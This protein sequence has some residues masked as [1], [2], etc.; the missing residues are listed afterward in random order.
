MREKLSEIAKKGDVEAFKNA[1][2]QIENIR[3]T[4]KNDKWN[5]LLFTSDYTK[6]D[7]NK[8]EHTKKIEMLKLLLEKGIELNMS[9][10]WGRPINHVVF[11]IR[12][13]GEWA[14]YDTQ[15]R[16][17]FIYELLIRSEFTLPLPDEYFRI[18][19]SELKKDEF[20]QYVGNRKITDPM[21]FK[22]LQSDIK[23]AVEAGFFTQ[24]EGEEWL[25][26]IREVSS[27]EPMQYMLIKEHFTTKNH[28]LPRSFDEVNS[29]IQF[30]IGERS[31]AYS[32]E[33]LERTF[34][35]AKNINITS[36]TQEQAKNHP[37]PLVKDWYN[38]KFNENYKTFSLV[39]ERLVD[40]D[41]A[42]FLFVSNY[43]DLARCFFELIEH[44]DD[45]IT[46][47]DRR[48]MLDLF[49][50]VEKPSAMIEVTQGLAKEN[51]VLKERVSTLET[52][53]DSMKKKFDDLEKLV[54]NLLNPKAD[55][56]QAFQK[57]DSYVGLVQNGNK[58]IQM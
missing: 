16:N 39:R 41:D 22:K 12:E 1:L 42:L 4:D 58:G 55:K 29:E 7:N 9:C 8:V 2:D 13:N 56:Q 27:F 49:E 17:M 57:S 50:N 43:D 5:A 14:A 37:N 24:E 23:L 51:K 15:T 31:S 18:G 10:G 28:I 44:H 35:P 6:I 11:F 30:L 52:Q 45:K 20:L 19:Q 21:K 32:L 34:L 40:N 46:N 36:L 33:Q 26:N 48:N 38:S 54:G 3:F 25:Q 53:M 47:L